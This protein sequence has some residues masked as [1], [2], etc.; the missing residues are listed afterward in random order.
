MKEPGPGICLWS[1]VRDEERPAAD[2]GKLLAWNLQP[3]LLSGR[4]GL[5]AAKISKEER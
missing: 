4:A 2:D 3:L 1:A 5:S